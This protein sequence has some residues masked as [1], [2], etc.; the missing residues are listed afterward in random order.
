[1]P[2]DCS[3]RGQPRWR[4][5]KIIKALETSGAPLT[6]PRFVENGGGL[7]TRCGDLF[8]QFDAGFD[9]LKSMPTL[10]ARRAAAIKLHPMIKEAISAMRVRDTAAGLNAD[11]VSL[12]G[13]PNRVSRCVVLELYSRSSSIR[14]VNHCL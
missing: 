4:L 2:P 14:S 6:Q 5:P 9:K 11:H 8:S 3:E 1:M 13:D 10:S 7:D 12:R